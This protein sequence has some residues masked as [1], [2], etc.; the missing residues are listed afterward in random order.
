MWQAWTA[1]NVRYEDVGADRCRVTLTGEVCMAVP[2]L[3]ALVER[4]I[5]HTVTAALQ[6]LPC[7]VRPCCSRARDTAWLGFALCRQ[8]LMRRLR[9]MHYHSCLFTKGVARGYASIASSP[10]LFCL[11]VVVSHEHSCAEA[12][13]DFAGPAAALVS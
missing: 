1:Q 10:R 2:G 6:L 13:K 8:Q 4:V 3:G 9:Q 5:V 7:L 12:V 11:L